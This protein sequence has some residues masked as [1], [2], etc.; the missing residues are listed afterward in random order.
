MPLL[1][2]DGLEGIAPGRGLAEQVLELGDLGL[3]LGDLALEV[4]RLAVG[5][6]P[7][8]LLGAVR[9]LARP[10]RRRPLAAAFAG[11]VSASCCASR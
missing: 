2:R 8:P 4:G 6:F 11:A 7:L 10:W 5:E 9:G 1:G 3:D